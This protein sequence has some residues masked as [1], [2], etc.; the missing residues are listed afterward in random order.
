[1]KN[2]S[3]RKFFCKE[4]MFAIFLWACAVALVIYQQA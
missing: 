4:N 2:Y 1:M 3:Q